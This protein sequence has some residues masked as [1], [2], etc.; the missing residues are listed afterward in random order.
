M[1]YAKRVSRTILPLIAGLVAGCTTSGGYN[2]PEYQLPD[3]STVE[4]TETLTLPYRSVRVYIQGGESLRWKSVNRYLPYC[5][6]GLNRNRN[7]Q[8]LAREIQPTR[9]T[10]GDF[11]LGVEAR[12]DPARQPVHVA[13]ADGVSVLR[14]AQSAGREG[15]GGTPWPYTFYTRIE[16]YSDQAPQVDD[17]TCAYDGDST[18]GNLTLDEIRDTLGDLV[19]L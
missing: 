4:L 17:L 6:F 5:S 8:P 9:F 11:R 1:N 7:N 2:T 14:F 15:N 19:R 13:G 18:D 12:L 16:L 10:T 3:G